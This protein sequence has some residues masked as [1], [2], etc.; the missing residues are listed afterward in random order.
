[1][2]GTL[3]LDS[4]RV[5]TVWGVNFV[6]SFCNRICQVKKWRNLRGVEERSGIPSGRTWSVFV[7]EAFLA[8]RP[9]LPLPF[10]SPSRPL[11]VPFALQPAGCKWV[12]AS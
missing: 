7:N 5:F 3:L 9:S 10:P 1:M 4:Q 2:S 12:G 11:P 8:P 6:L